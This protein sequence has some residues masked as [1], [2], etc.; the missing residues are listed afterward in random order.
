MHHASV[1]GTVSSFDAHRGLGV[2]TGATGRS[3]A[4]HATA[5]TDGSRDIDVG[6]EVAFAVVAGHRGRMEARSLTRLGDA[7]R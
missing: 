3:W 5:I 6:A 4:F 7:A 2:V 1:L